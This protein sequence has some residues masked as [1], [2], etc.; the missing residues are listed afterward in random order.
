MI[1]V[2]YA[3]STSFGVELTSPYKNK[4][5]FEVNYGQS[6]LCEDDLRIGFNWENNKFVQRKYK[7]EKLILKKINHNEKSEF[8][9]I[10]K[11]KLYREKDFVTSDYARLNRCYT[12]Q[13]MGGNPFPKFCSELY[14]G[15][16]FKLDQIKCEQISFNPD[17]LFLDKPFDVSLAK[18]SSYK[19]SFSIAHGKCARF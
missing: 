13:S 19:D 12:R 14:R 4:T 2:I 1:L 9:E 11:S 5:D 3:S 8:F 7:N 15:K 10:C 16:N 18:S 17:G 6:I